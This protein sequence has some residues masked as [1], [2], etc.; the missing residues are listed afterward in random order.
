MIDSIFVGFL[1]SLMEV[2]EILIRRYPIH[3]DDEYWYCQGN[4]KITKEQY[5]RIKGDKC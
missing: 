3:K 2:C 5:D 1:V 4:K